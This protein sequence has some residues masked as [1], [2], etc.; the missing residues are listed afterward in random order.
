MQHSE[1]TSIIQL[2]YPNLWSPDGRKQSSWQYLREN[3][4]PWDIT[5]QQYSPEHILRHM[6]YNNASWIVV[7]W[8]CKDKRI[9]NEQLLPIPFLFSYL[10]SWYNFMLSFQDASALSITGLAQV[11]FFFLH[12]AQQGDL[13]D[14]A[15]V[16]RWNF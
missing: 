3:F 6:L 1:Q 8:L 5:G 2:F 9:A 13:I 16:A 10:C 4:V 15:A 14:E 12:V 7:K 11:F